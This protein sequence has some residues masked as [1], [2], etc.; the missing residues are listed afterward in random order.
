[1]SPGIV[2]AFEVVEVD[3]HEGERA[4]MAIA[5][6]ELLIKSGHELASV[7]QAGKV[8]GIRQSPQSCLLD[9]LLSDID[10]DTVPE[11]AGR[12]TLGLGAECDPAIAM[13]GEAKAKLGSDRNSPACRALDGSHD[14]WMVFVM[15]SGQHMAGVLLQVTALDTG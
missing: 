2:D 14:A 12:S 7:G 15:Q 1:M 9:H 4:A 11:H 6:G 8:V 5:P 10:H 3:Q 13:T